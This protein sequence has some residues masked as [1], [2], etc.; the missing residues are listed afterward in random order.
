L[1]G[2]Q[3]DGRD[4]LG[5]VGLAKDLAS[6]CGQD[7]PRTAFHFRFELPRTP[8]GVADEKAKLAFVLPEQPFDIVAIRGEIDAVEDFDLAGGLMRMEG[9][10]EAFAGAALVEVAFGFAAEFEGLFAGFLD[11]RLQGAVQDEPD[12][13][14]FVVLDHQDDALGEVG[15]EQRRRRQQKMPLQRVHPSLK[16]PARGEFVIGRPVKGETA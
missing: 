7:Y 12:S 5:P 8:A 13:A 15:V 4:Q 3:A 16:I 1:N 9:H 14:L 6:F 11:G 10:E 2:S